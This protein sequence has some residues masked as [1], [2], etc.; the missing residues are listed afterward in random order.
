MDRCPSFNTLNRRKRRGTDYRIRWRCS[1]SGI[2]ILSIQGGDIEPGTTRSAD[3]SAGRYHSFYAFE[4]IKS[5]AVAA[6]LE[7]P[8]GGA[9]PANICNLCGR[10]MGV[11]IQIGRG[12]RQQMFRDPR[13]RGGQRTLAFDRFAQALRQAIAPWARSAA[14]MVSSQ[15]THWEGLAGYGRW[16][17]GFIAN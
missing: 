1:Q 8:F 2:A 16:V 7:P 9:D 6:G 5:V 15:G 10:R 3:A 12:L 17:S 14:A 11:Q 13:T 4:G